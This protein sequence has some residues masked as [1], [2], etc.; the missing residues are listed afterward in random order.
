MFPD[1]QTVTYIK[2]Y[3]MKMEKWLSDNRIVTY[4]KS[5]SRF[6]NRTVTYFWVILYIKKA[7]F[8]HIKLINLTQIT[9]LLHMYFTVA[10]Q[11]ELTL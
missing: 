9:K 10:L 6:D 4:K 7:R 8:L 2:F 11:T 1:N 5:K 3:K